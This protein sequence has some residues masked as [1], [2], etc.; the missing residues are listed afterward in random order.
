MTDKFTC[1]LCVCVG[2]GGARWLGIGP[3]SSNSSPK[4]KY[5]LHVYYLHQ[6]IK[7][8]LHVYCILHLDTDI[9]SQIILHSLFLNVLCNRVTGCG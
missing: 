6:P 3:L 9:Y 8:H 1:L 2:G 5:T 7:Y 4:V